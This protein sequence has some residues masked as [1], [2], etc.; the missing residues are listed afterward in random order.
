MVDRVFFA[1][2]LPYRLEMF[3]IETKFLHGEEQFGNHAVRNSISMENIES[4]ADSDTFDSMPHRMSEIQCFAQSFFPGITLYNSRFHR[5]GF[6]YQLQKIF[7]RH[8]G[9]I[10]LHRFSHMF[11]IG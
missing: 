9:K 7:F 6:T 10:Y 4:T 11:F 2:K 5:N 3:F 8:S 1:D